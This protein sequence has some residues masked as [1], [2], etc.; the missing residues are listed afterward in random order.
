MFLTPKEQ[1]KLRRQRRMADLKEQQAKVRLG[2]EPAPPP[3]VKKSNLM[4]VLGEEAVK[5]PTAVEARVNREIEE[6]AQKH[7]Q[8]NEERK[9]TKEQALEKLG[10]KQEGDASKGIFM[11]VYKIDNLSNGRHRF[12]ISK[13]AEQN[14]LTGVCLLHPKFNL[15]V[16]EGGRHSINFYKKLMLNRIDWTENSAPNNVREGNTEA[17]AAWLNAEDDEGKLKDLG[18]NKCV[19]LWEGEV[20]ARAF[21]KWGSRVCETDA[22]ARDALARGKLETFWTLAKSEG[23]P[24]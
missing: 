8:M 1:A 12:K 23:A 11:S 22:A 4:R 18:L 10:Q 17:L 5:D 7:L 21:R 24:V 6:R 16:V 9:L 14:A 19:L 20:K 3:K 2:L 15:V 13:N